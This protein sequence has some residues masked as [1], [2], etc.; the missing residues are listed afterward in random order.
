MIFARVNLKTLTASGQPRPL[1]TGDVD[2][3]AA[4]IKQVG[5]IQPITVRTTIV[6]NGI[7]EDGYQIVAG[8]HRVAACRSLGW[9]EIDAIVI[10]SVEHLQAE[11]IEIDENL[12]RSELTSAQRSSFTK[13]RK[14]AWEALHPEGE[15]VEQVVPPVAK[16]GHSQSKGFAAETST[17][18]GMTKQAINRHV[19]R[20]E[21]LGDDLDRI[22]GTSLDKGTELDALAAMPTPERAALVDRAAAGE[23]VTAVVKKGKVAKPKI[24]STRIDDESVALREQLESL[25]AEIEALRESSAE[26]A[27][28]AEE[29]IADNDSMAAVFESNDQLADAMKEILRL[30]AEVRSVRES[31][32]GKMNECHELN[33]LLRSYKSRCERLEKAAAK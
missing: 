29:A 11:L 23:Q 27:K 28:N 13:R 22:V 24:D 15:Q 17:V 5:L 2:K 32:G 20:A 10:D 6:M 25:K 7:A 9:T 30:K 19:A 14:Q 18:S 1:I 8:H 3:L 26:I 33:R 12:V 21:A 31:L 4:S 16:H